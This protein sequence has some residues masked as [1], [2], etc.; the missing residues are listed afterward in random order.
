MAGHPSSRRAPRW[1]RIRYRLGQFR[2]ALW[3]RIAPDER[4]ILALWLPPRAAALFQAMPRRDQRHSL[5][6][7]YTLRAAGHGEPDL[8]AAAL[9][10]DVGKTVHDGRPVRTWHRVIV[11]LL[12]TL[13]PGLVAQLANEQPDNWRYPLH[14]HL[15]HPGQGAQLARAAGCSQRTAML[16]ERHQD[17]PLGPP[18][19]EMERLLAALQAADDMN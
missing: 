2:A 18:G 16:I 11:V 9:L 13:K 4:A 6:V 7:F 15:H 8:L 3:P 10:H 1:R 14:A 12:D 17:K 19:D 5:N